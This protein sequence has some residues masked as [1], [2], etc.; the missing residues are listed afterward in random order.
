MGFGIKM[1][2]LTV[3]GCLV[4]LLAACAGTNA[5][6]GDGMAAMPEWLGGE[7]A[8]VPPRAWQFGISGLACRPSTA[9]VGVKLPGREWVSPRLDRTLIV[10]SAPAATADG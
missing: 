4:F 2:R 5:A 3:A 9:W 6:I 7:P 8:D 1:I 10:S